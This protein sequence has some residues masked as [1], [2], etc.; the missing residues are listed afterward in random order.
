VHVFLKFDMKESGYI[1]GVFSK[2]IRT[3]SLRRL[4]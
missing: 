1:L 4:L 2:H 3:Q